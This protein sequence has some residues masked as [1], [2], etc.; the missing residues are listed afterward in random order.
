MDTSPT[1][2]E[3]AAA[4]EAPPSSA[5]SEVITGN[6]LDVIRQLLPATRERDQVLEI[7]G[8]VLAD[9]EAL[10][11]HLTKLLLHAKKNEGVSI[12]QL[13]LA[14]GA[15]GLA[16]VDAASGDGEAVQPVELD[17]ADQKLRETSEIDKAKK[18]NETIRPPQQP[19][20]RTPPPDHLPRV[21]HRIPVPDAERACPICGAERS[22]IGHDVTQ[23]ID[24]EP[25][26]VIVRVDR[27][28]KLACLPCE[29]Q[30]VCAP[31][32]DK[33]VEGGMY[34]LR[35]VAHLLVS[36]F[37]DGVPA[38]R[39]REQLA[40]LGLDL[41]VSTLIDQLK[42]STELLRP[43]WRVALDEVITSRVMHMDGTGLP[44][45]DRELK[46]KTR[47]GTLWGYVGVCDHGSTAAYL[48]CSTGKKIAQRP[49]E[50][51]PQDVLGR[52]TGYVVADAA[53][54]F[55]ASFER[56]ELIECGCNMH[57]RR[58]FTKALDAGDQRAALA[59]AAYKKIYKIEEEIREHDPPPTPDQVLAARIEYSKPVF[60]ELVAWC[61]AH[62]PS[63]LPSS[64]L[65]AAIRYMLNHRVALGRFLTD[66]R[67]PLDNGPA[68]RLHVRCAIARKNFLFAGSDDGGERAAIAFTILGSC[69]LLGINP[70]EY[71]AD[72][73]P[74]LSRDIRLIDMPA[75]LPVYWKARRDATKSA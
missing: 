51:G 66:G 70:L 28:E 43:L 9:N 14:L 19:N 35:L 33:I 22:C 60:D 29:G 59:L 4:R 52:R 73:L 63:V 54:I 58:Y 20:L 50:L 34:G 32:G 68:E 47:L 41:P 36:K 12:S 72:V 10:H 62:Q 7:V 61:R 53:G 55:D 2:I 67:I 65:G 39:Q 45:L 44:V 27:R 11:R 18:A 64:K 42:W 3:T 23:T 13:R 56:P 49:G 69:R 5:T 17:A 75:L 38:H 8:R 15:L 46:G 37:V 6:I 24:M 21:D 30:I 74:I 26:R 57:S 16:G 25:A 31:R 71:L 48:Y 40:R 1:E